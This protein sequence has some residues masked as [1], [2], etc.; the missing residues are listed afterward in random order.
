MADQII[1][2]FGTNH[3]VVTR[4]AISETSDTVFVQEWGGANWKDV[5]SYNTRSDDYAYTNARE[6][7]ERLAKRRGMHTR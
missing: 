4:P 6:Y 2:T 1:G 3:R 5:L 7:A